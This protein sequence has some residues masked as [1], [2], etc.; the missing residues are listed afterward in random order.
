MKKSELRVKQTEEL[1]KSVASDLKKKDDND[2]FK[3]SIA[4]AG[5]EGSGGDREGGDEAS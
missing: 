5:S 1:E 2:K 3:E 4:D